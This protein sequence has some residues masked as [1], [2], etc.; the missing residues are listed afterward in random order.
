MGNSSSHFLAL[1]VI[2]SKREEISP[3][4]LLMTNRKSYM[5]FQLTRVD[6]FDD[7]GWRWTAIRS[8]FSVLRGILQI[9]APTM[10]KRMKIDP[11]CQRRNCS[12]LRYFSAMQGVHLLGASNKGG[13]GETSHFRDNNVNISKTVRDTS[14]Y[15]TVFRKN[16]HSHF[17]SYLHELFVDLNKN[18]SECTQGLTDSENVKIGY[19]LR[20]MT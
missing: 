7:R 6:W 12:P 11:Y 5:R 8:N 19:S 2:I 4:I 10:A 17:L 9:W 20:S 1:N 14:S 3:K 15:Y 13:V 16:T 18:C